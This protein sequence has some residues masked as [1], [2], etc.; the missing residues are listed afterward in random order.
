MTGRA[1]HRVESFPH[2]GEIVNE[3][4]KLRTTQ[5]DDR[6]QKRERV[7]TFL[8]QELLVEDVKSLGVALGYGGL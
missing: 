4:A 5:E 8:S 7:M 1:N 2:D 6:L 3:T